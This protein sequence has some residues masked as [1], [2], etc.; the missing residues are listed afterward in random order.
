MF[1]IVRC[2]SNSFFYNFLPGSQSE[3]SGEEF[4]SSDEADNDEGEELDQAENRNEQ[5]FIQRQVQSAEEADH[6]IEVE[7]DGNAGHSFSIPQ[8]INPQL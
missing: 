3:A 1:F 7:D 8:R 4:E 5:N 6:N 2:L